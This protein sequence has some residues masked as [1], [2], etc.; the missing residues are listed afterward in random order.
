MIALWLG[1]LAGLLG[2]VL[3]LIGGLVSLAFYSRRPFS[4]AATSAERKFVLAALATAILGSAGL[5]VFP[6]YQVSS[7]PDSVSTAVSSA[8]PASTSSVSAPMSACTAHSSTLFRVNGPQVIP[9]FTVPVLLAV[10]PFAF[11]KRRS[12]CLVFS[13][14]A[15]LLAGQAAVGM[16][17]YGLAFS[18]SS[19]LLVLA[20]FIGLFN[21]RA[22]PVAA[23][24]PRDARS[25]RR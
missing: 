2:S 12:R 6:A 25:V 24:G 1:A 11:L 20:G 17:G 22:Q 21:N 16:S 14:C 13:V 10:I 8:P 4:T 9:F 3:L 19:V 23:D 7:C 18:P 15:F 5:F